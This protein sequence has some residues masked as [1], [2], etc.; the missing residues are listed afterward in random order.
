LRILN[1]LEE[2]VCARAVKLDSP[3]KNVQQKWKRLSF[4]NIGDDV[5]AQKRKMPGT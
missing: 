4:K 5:I 1:R 2:G 3:D